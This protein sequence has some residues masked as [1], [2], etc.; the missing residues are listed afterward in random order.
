MSREWRRAIKKAEK[1]IDE[2]SLFHTEFWNQKEFITYVNQL[3][4]HLDHYDSLWFS[5]HFDNAFAKIVEDCH[6]EGLAERSD[7][8][9]LSLP[10][11]KDQRGKNNR[12]ALEKLARFKL[13]VRVNEDLHAR[14]LI[15]F[16][17]SDIENEVV[18]GSFDFNRDGLSQAKLNSGI[19]SRHTDVFNSA[20]KFF[21]SVWE[22]P[23]TMTL[24]E[25][26]GKNE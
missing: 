17:E 5:G 21:E 25:Y 24:K 14:M 15:L 7:I 4:D 16:N 18:L 1:A 23:D 12:R 20:K 9:I 3:K 26:I 19:K 2:L 8:R 6:Y 22:S 10:F 11:S 13:K